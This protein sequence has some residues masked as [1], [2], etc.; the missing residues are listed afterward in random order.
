MAAEFIEHQE[1]KCVALSNQQ[2]ADRYQI[3]Q[4]EWHSD[5]IQHKYAHVFSEDV[6]VVLGSDYEGQHTL[7]DEF[8]EV[9][10]IRDDL[11]KQFLSASAP[12][13]ESFTHYYLPVNIERIASTIKINKKISDREKCRLNPVDVVKAVDQLIKDTD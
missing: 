1:I 10:K 11:R 6:L 5:E 8:F 9:K 2:L 12:K 13:E 7:R 4:D 3:I